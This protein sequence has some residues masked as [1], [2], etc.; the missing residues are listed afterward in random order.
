M[1]PVCIRVSRRESEA[2]GREAAQASRSKSQVIVARIFESQYDL[3][4]VAQA[5]RAALRAMNELSR[6]A[7]LLAML[8]KRTGDGI[9]KKVPGKMR[10]Q[11]RELTAAYGVFRARPELAARPKYLLDVEAVNGVPE[12]AAAG[13]RASTVSVYLSDSQFAEVSIKASRWA[14]ASG[15]ATSRK[16]FMSTYIRENFL[17]WPLTLNV[18]L[19]VTGTIDAL[20]EEIMACGRFV[21]SEFDSGRCEAILTKEADRAVYGQFKAC[22]KLSSLLREGDAA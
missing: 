21:L 18:P 22:Q 20:R 16:G 1:K 10:W 19:A 3:I 2:L 11:L 17:G 13:G 7:G 12:P 4:N 15:K 6:Q 8:S 14:E 9:M 5:K